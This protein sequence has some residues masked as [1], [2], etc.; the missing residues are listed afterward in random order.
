MKT[1]GI[2]LEFF[3]KL[4]SSFTLAWGRQTWNLH[5]GCS[6]LSTPS[7]CAANSAQ[8]TRMHAGDGSVPVACG[9][10]IA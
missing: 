9:A 5:V 6:A 1:I 8:K 4:I 2:K 7:E 3:S 10:E